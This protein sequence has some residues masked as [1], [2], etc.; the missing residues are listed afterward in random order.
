[1]SVAFQRLIGELAQR[2]AQI[3]SFTWT[4]SEQKDC[5]FAWP[6]SEL[7]LQLMAMDKAWSKQDR[8]ALCS[9]PFFFALKPNRGGW[10]TG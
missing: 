9:L 8:R 3:H 6:M 10:Q 2:N 5:A 1:M 4:L 7:L